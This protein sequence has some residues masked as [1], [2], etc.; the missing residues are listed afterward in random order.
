MQ[1][2][3]DAGNCYLRILSNLLSLCPRVILVFKGNDL[4][5]FGLTIYPPL[6]SFNSRGVDFGLQLSTNTGGVAG[7]TMFISPQAN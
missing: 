5:I 7:N 2:Y 3:Y 6:V 4:R 1:S